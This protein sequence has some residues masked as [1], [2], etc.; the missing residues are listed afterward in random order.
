MG[1][2]NENPGVSNE[3]LGSLNLGVS[4]ETSLGVS[5][6]TIMMMISSQ[7]RIIVTTNRYKALELPFSFF[8]E[9]KGGGGV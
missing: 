7:T 9:L 6:S 5:N 3:N 2:S 1:V 8:I 4:T